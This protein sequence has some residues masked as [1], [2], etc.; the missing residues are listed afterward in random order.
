[1][2]TTYLFKGG[3]VYT[4]DSSNSKTEALVA[5]DGEIIYVG[6]EKGAAEILASS[7]DPFSEIDLAGGIL[8]P[9]FIDAHDHYAMG[10][11]YRP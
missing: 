8:L 9:G 10:G 7:A 5:R 11:A 3:L 1:M 4:V 2:P 6:S